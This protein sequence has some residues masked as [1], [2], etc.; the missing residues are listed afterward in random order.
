V[1]H[2]ARSAEPQ[3]VP[4]FRAAH[5]GR[6][7][8]HQRTSAH[9]S[10]RGR[11][12]QRFSRRRARAFQVPGSNAVIH[13]PASVDRSQPTGLQVFLHGAMRTVEFYV[14]GHRPWADEA[15]VIFLA[16]YSGGGTG[17]R[18][19][20]TS[21]ATSPSWTPACNGRSIASGSTLPG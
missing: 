5:W 6:P 11:V 2:S 17:M 9:V 10:R 8:R 15:G 14:N 12:R 13:I 18:S 21:R 16:P 7:A 3:P 1:T 20:A 4:S 19:E